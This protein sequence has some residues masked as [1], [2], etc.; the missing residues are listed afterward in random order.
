MDT[1]QIKHFNIRVYALIINENKEILLSDEFRMGM[2]MTKFPGGGLKFG[3]GTIDCIK[4]EAKE[5]FNQEIQIIEHFYTTDFFQ[6]AYFFP[7]RQLI[8]IY[9]LAKFNGKIN[10]RISSKPFDFKEDAEGA[11]SFRWIPIKDVNEKIMTLPVDKVVTRLLNK[12]FI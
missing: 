7:E 10:F 4:R 9:Y 2:R 12:K 8:S 11:Q 6:Q 1:S 3:E 5:E